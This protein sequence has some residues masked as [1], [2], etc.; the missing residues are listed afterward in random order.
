[1][2]EGYYKEEII[3]GKDNLMKESQRLGSNTNGLNGGLHL[4]Q[5][6]ERD[7]LIPLDIK[8]ITT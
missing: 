4:L 5:W 7:I 2:D 1:M 6:G 3:N 8:V